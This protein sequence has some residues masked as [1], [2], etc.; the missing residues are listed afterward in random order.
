MQ[1]MWLSA[2]SPRRCWRSGGGRQKYKGANNVRDNVPQD[3]AL[4]QIIALLS[5]A[6]PD[7]LHIVKL[8]LN[9]YLTPGV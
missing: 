7:Q 9:G 2:A 6:T 8:L 5:K 4:Q 1:V 3:P